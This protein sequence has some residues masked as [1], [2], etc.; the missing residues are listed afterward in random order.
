M[1]YELIKNSEGTI[2]GC[3]DSE[4]GTLTEQQANDAIL[5]NKEN[6]TES[7]IKEAQDAL[8]VFSGYALLRAERNKK[9]SQSDWIITMHKEKGTNIP[10]AW[11]TYRQSL[12]DITDS[13]TS[14]DDVTWPEKPE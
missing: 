5:C 13:A 9:L 4:N 6:P 2:A 1:G 11:K 3:V 14:L 7:E 10:A 12:R 8:N